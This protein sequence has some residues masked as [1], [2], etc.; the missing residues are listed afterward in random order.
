M[1]VAILSLAPDGA[2]AADPSVENGES[3]FRRCR[4]C[5]DVGPNA[6]NKVGPHLN[7]I[8]GRKAGTVEGFNYSPANKEKG[9]KGLVWTEETLFEYLAKPMSYIQGTRMAFVGL[10]DEQDRKDVI[11]YIKT[12]SK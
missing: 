12:F 11:A 1:L 6:R 8:I 9:E 7:G 4:A 10:A 5:H 3:V 2:R